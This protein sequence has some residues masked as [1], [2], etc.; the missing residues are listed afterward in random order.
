MICSMMGCYHP[1]VKRYPWWLPVP[2]VVLCVACLDRWH[3]K[4]GAK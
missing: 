4:I 1:A 2:R 3:Q